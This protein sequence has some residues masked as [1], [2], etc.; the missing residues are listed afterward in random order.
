M[1]P[2]LTLVLG[3]ANSGKSGFAEGLVTATGRPRVYLATAQVWDDEM[4]AKVAAHRAARGNGWTTVEVPLEVG[5]VLAGC[6]PGAVVLLDCATL[7]LTNRMLADVPGDAG[8]A[9]LAALGACPAPV[10][11]VSNEV[12]MGVVPDTPLG[13]AFRGE[14]G[15]L[16]Q[17]LAAA[18][19]LAVL[20]VA[21]LPVVLKGALPGGPA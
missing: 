2:K 5:E 20:V 21:G 16:N 8:D 7:W 6:D 1:L 15:R 19:G 17:R 10:V 11:V 4:A 9:L 13:R 12:G 18:A 3:G 14:Q